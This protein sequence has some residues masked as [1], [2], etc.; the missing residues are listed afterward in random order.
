MIASTKLLGLC[1]HFSGNTLVSMSRIAWIAVFA[2]ILVFP[3]CGSK[4]DENHA[5]GIITYDVSFPYNSNELLS[6]I[7]PEEMIVAFRGPEITGSL[8]AML[9]IVR[10]S[11][12]VNNESLVFD[13][14]LKTHKGS[15][16]MTL[17]SAGVVRMLD[18]STKVRLIPTEKTDS[19]AGFLCSLTIAEFLQDSVPPIELWHT[20]D[21]PIKNPN[22][23]NPYHELDEFLLGYDVEQ[24]GMRM[25]VRARAVE[26][27]EVG[28]TRFAFPTGYE[29]VD[30]DGMTEVVNALLAIL[31]GD[32]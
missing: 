24:W 13:Q 1:T 3:G 9:G 28:E 4:E 20:P 23:C 27:C 32:E 12:Y 30:F 5:E 17:D 26:F 14:F 29:E 18:T 2:T 22:W 31:E 10:N 6:N 16:H 25:K 8:E 19:I 7:Y 21:I 15:H 11:F